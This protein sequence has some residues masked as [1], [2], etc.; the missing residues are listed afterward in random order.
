MQAGQTETKAVASSSNVLD[1]FGNSSTPTVS[2]APK[3][4]K[5]PAAVSKPEKKR[6][7]K[8]EEVE[9]EEE[10]EFKPKKAKK[11]KGVSIFKKKK[12]QTSD[13][14]AA[15][16][17]KKNKSKKKED[18]IRQEEVAAFRHRLKINVEGN[19]V[20]DPIQ[21]FDEMNEDDPAVGGSTKHVLLQN[22]EKSAY[23][24][25]TAVQMQA[26]PALLDK[27]DVLVAAPTGSGK[28]LTFAVPLLLNL[29]KP[30]KGHGV[31]GLVLAPT[32]ELAGQLESYIK[33][34][35]AGKKFKI[36]LLKKATA[37]ALSAGSSNKHTSNQCDILIATPLRLLHLLNTN[38][39]NLHQVQMVCL[40]EADKLFE[41]GFVEQVDAI[42]AACTN[43]KVQ[44][45]MLSATMMPGV[46]DMAKSVLKDPIK[47][48]IG[49]KNAGA[50]TIKQKL[51]FVGREAGK[52]LAVRQIVQEGLKPPV[53]I[54]LQNKER[55][56]ALFH[57][58]VYDGINVEVS[59][60]QKQR[61]RE[62]DTERER[63]S[64]RER[65]REREIDR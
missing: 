14:D 32:R 1:F 53:L 46:E 31:R 57:E 3:K 20:P 35:C 62:R 5:K 6:A 25:P 15:K 55:A 50:N 12:G 2:T 21:T 27:R 39:L 8:V 37:T 44:V 48:T 47:V 23:K 56:Q 38:S 64:V 9:S 42:L 63:A 45:A 40:D 41:M 7:A 49:T 33:R 60:V 52:L 24:E 18:Q 65:E 61:R 22:I 26:I 19:E 10:V 54:F 17:R 29:H 28:T 13:S 36:V 16:S 43:V 11:G 34:M 59:P 51:V 30:M 58:L 4:R